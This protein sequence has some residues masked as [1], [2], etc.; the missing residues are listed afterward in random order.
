MKNPIETIVIIAAVIFTTSC[1][2]THKP[3]KYPDAKRVDTVD[4]YFGKKVADPYRWLEDDNSAETKA[5][6]I[7]EN[8]VTNNYLKRI[9]FRKKLKERLSEIWNYPRVSAPW[10]EGGMYIFTKNDGLQNQSVYYRM[11]TLDSNPE[12][13]IDPNKLSKDGTVAISAFSVSKDGNYLGYG[14][15]RGGSDWSEFF[16]KDMKSGQLLSDHLKWIK[17]SGIAWY[18]NGFFYTRYPEPAEGDELKGANLNSKIYYHT[19]GTRQS[20]DKLI[21]EDINHPEWGFGAQVTDDDEFLIIYATESTGGNALYYKR[22]GVKSAP[23]VKVIEGFDSYFSV[24]DH[25]QG[26]FYVHTNSEAPKYKLMCIK[27][28]AYHFDNWKSV[29]PESADDVLMDVSVFNNRIVAKYQAD[30]H[31]EI[32]IFDDE[33]LFLH[34]VKLPGLGTVSGFSGEKNDTVTFYTF[35]SYTYPNVVYKYS[36]KSNSSEL[37]SSTTIDFKIDDYEI[38][39]VFYKSKDGTEIPMYLVYKKGLEFNGENPTW[40]YG[41]G[42]FNISLTPRFDVRRLVWLENGGVYAVAN[43]RGGGEYGEIWHR[44]GTKMQKQNVFDDFIYAAKFL[45][46]NHCT[47]PEKLVIQGGSNG[48][49]L[50][51]A[52]VNQRPDL[53]KVALPAVGVMDMLR[54]QNFT[55]GRYWAADYGTSADSEEMFRYLLGYSPL[56]NIKPDVEYPAVMV[57]T[58][59]HDDRVVPAHSFKYIA[60]LQ[61]TYKGDNPVLIRIETD[62][63]HGAGKS[64]SKKIE[65]WTDLYSF[66]FYQ[67]GITPEY[68]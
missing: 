44:A 39:Q 45:I 61:H 67:L 19:V 47:N 57:T 6:V 55:I 3:L 14:I 62:A 2:N 54:Y 48:G 24:V 1:N 56:H 41:Y 8:R 25:R 10:K 31:S 33:G 34:K 43:L 29:I 52:V 16:V 4:E 35:S 9:P 68:K 12:V 11:E 18:K 64:V 51:G 15:S 26:K 42:G 36:V 17:F 63:G 32:L 13:I 5:W 66:V 7:A 30:A 46:S 28:D 60:T 23:V 59:D 49:L 37:Y 20:Q 53:F 40:L 58:A 65:E 38:K 22:L 21:Y 50:I 27:A